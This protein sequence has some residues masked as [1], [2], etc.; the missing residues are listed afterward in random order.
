MKS[1]SKIAAVLGLLTLLLV[2]ASGGAAQV[3]AEAG[4]TASGR[5]RARKVRIA[6]EVGG[7]IL[8]VHAR[9]GDKVQRGDLLVELDAQ[10]LLSE[11]ARAEAAVEAA[12]ADLAAVQ[13]GPMTEEIAAAR[14]QVAVARAERDGALSAWR[15]AQAALENP[16]DLG[17]QLIEARTRVALAEQAVEGAKA[18][19]T[20]QRI[21]R[22]REKQGG[23]DWKVRAAEANLAAAQADLETAR[24]VLA[25]LEALRRRPLGLIAVANAAEGRYRLAEAQVALAE[26]QLAD[27]LARPTSQE[28]AVATA[29]VRQAEAQANVLRA[30][31]S[32]FSLHSPLDGVVLEQMLWPGEVAAP[33]V[34]ILTVADLSE[35]TLDAYVP[36]NRIGQVALGQE[37][38]IL[39]DSFPQRPFRGWVIRIGDRPEFTPRNVATREERL[40]T[41]YVVQIRVP[42]A[43]GLLKSGMPADVY[44]K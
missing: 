21:L 11:L 23:S 15:N 35:L 19:L 8:A 5:L 29:A 40:N 18:D 9:E 31:L 39:V 42:N 12:R 32:A 24:A 20:A 44:F 43:E 6:G 28:I 25:H 41:F 36:E 38:R 22:D 26:A 1:W 37:V 17:R 10:P 2:L 27:L 16:Q 14:A 33:T 30:R 34:P 7:R 13:A 4:L 3:Q